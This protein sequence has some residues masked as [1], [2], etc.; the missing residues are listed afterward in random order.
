MTQ[1]G[2]C[3]TPTPSTRRSVSADGCVTHTLLD[4]LGWT[5]TTC[6]CGHPLPHLNPGGFHDPEEGVPSL[7][8]REAGR[9]MD[10]I[11]ILRWD[12]SVSGPARVE[13][14]TMLFVHYIFYKSKCSPHL[15]KGSDAEDHTTQIRI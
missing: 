4:P 14:N 13:P 8:P 15:S 2:L 3:R 1:R 7:A 11:R 6:R 10:S 12:S 5:K 9:A